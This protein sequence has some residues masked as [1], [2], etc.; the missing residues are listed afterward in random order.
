MAARP[1]RLLP[2]RALAW[3]AIAVLHPTARAQESVEPQSPDDERVSVNFQATV[4][5]G[6]HPSF[7]ASHSGQDSLHPRFMS[8]GVR[9]AA[10]YDRPILHPCDNSD[11]GPGNVFTERLHVAF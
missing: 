8:W 11:R 4:A 7:H 3:T 9:A 6:P 2:T 10:A 1:L 5:T